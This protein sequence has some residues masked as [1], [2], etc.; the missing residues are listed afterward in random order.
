M[1]V[2]L[3]FK[4]DHGK[5]NHNHGSNVNQHIKNELEKCFSTK[6][7]QVARVYFPSHK[8]VKVLLSSEKLVDDVFKHE[9]FFVSSGFQP[10]LTMALKTAR[11][12]FCYGFDPVLLSTYDNEAI[13]QNL[14]AEDWMVTSVYVLQSKRSMKIEF[15]SRDAANKFLKLKNI[16]ILGIRLENKHMEPEID[17]TID[18]CYNCGALD[19]GHT[20]ELCPNRTCCLRCGYQGHTFFECPTIPN[21]PPSQY[22]EHHKSQAYCIPCAAVNGHC[23]L[24]HRSCPTKKRII[25][26]RIQNIRSARDKENTDKEKSSVISK[27]I[28]LELSNMDKWPK[29][30]TQ[31]NEQAQNYPMSAIITL[32]LIDEVHE[33]GSFQSKL[34]QACHANNYQKFKYDINHNAAIMFVQNVCANP[35]IEPIS[36]AKSPSEFQIM[37]QPVQATGSH[38]SSQVYSSSQPLQAT[39]SQPPLRSFRFVRDINKY[40]ATASATDADSESYTSDSNIRKKR[41][42]LSPK[43]TTNKGSLNDIKSR[44]EDQTYIIN[45]NNT[46]EIS[47]KNEEISVNDLLTLYETAQS[48]LSA[49]KIQVIEGLLKKAVGMDKD[50][51]VNVNIIRVSEDFH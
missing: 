51:K 22:S 27:Q 21:I 42:R 17:P 1:S 39:G 37:S 28:A 24:N 43:K 6:G 26:R 36:N 30:P 10:S 32:A 7:I 13:K 18:Q 14:I 48:E 34:D 20:R 8:Y 25:Q 23:S 49:T 50:M 31:I 29:M 19:P 2:K 38:P 47:N 15:K 33:K 35:R 45:T 12:V 4:L 5:L 46:S 16:N 40:L 44:L 11:T 9:I 3:N 41:Q